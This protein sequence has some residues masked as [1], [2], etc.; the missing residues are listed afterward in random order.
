[1]RARGPLRANIA[2]FERARLER[3]IHEACAVAGVSSDRHH[4]M[5]GCGFR[6]FGSREIR[7]SDGPVRYDESEPYED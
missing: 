1:M 6:V 2:H 5:S 4:A 3:A 7:V